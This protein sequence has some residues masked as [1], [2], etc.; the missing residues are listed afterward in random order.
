MIFREKL[1]LL[2]KAKG[3]QQIAVVENAKKA[4]YKTSG[5][6]ISRLL[7]G[8]IKSPGLEKGKILARGLE[9]SQKYIN[10]DEMD[11]EIKK[12]PVRIVTQESLELCI[13]ENRVD[14]Q[15][16][17]RLK[18]V[19]RNHPDPPKTIAGWKSILLAFRADAQSQ[20]VDL[21]RIK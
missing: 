3:I 1:E 15:M 6:Y 13:S 5:G 11:A 4:G 2:L 16:V 10:T 18:G 7:K 17:K 9:I 12:D 20:S 21:K 19:L 14:T 8:A